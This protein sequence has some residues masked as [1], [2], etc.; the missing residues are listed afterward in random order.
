ME[1][2]YSVKW[3]RHSGQTIRIEDM[4]DLEVVRAH[5]ALER[6]DVSDPVAGPLLDAI[7][8]EAE[9]RLNPMF[10]GQREAA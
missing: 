6:E 5:H 3:V 7:A 9:R 2:R 8:I 1:S 10:E 4:T